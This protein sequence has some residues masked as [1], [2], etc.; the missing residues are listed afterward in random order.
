MEANDVC[1][2]CYTNQLTRK[3][4]CNHQICSSCCVRLNRALCPF[5]REK[6]TFN[7]DEI[8]Q[9]VKLGLINGYNW[10]SQ[11]PT[12][13]N[14]PALGLPNRQLH[15]SSIEVRL[16]QGGS[17]LPNRYL[18]YEENNTEA[19]QYLSRVIRN[20][21]RNRRRCFSLDEIL[22]RRKELNERKARH[23]EMKNGRLRK[24]TNWWEA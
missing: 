16:A 9:R 18:H 19:P 2:I 17:L 4:P 7:S 5:C 8:K 11:P 21:T 6:F 13:N 10:E 15:L 14:G 12:T 22:E 24:L 3:L 23:W 1:G 20:A